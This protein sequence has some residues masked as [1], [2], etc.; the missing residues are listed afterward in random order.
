ME[1]QSALVW[2]AISGVSAVVSAIGSIAIAWMVYRFT[3]Q[4]GKMQ[5]MKDINS[6]WQIWNMAI[7]SNPEVA[8]FINRRK[9]ITDGGCMS[10]DEERMFA[11]VFYQVN[12]L[13]DLMLAQEAGLVDDEFT[14]ALREDAQNYVFSEKEMVDRIMDGRWGYP[15]RFL[16]QMKEALRAREVADAA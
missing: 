5:A 9:K 4:T 12:I 1:D 11:S 2:S 3:K 15:D 6:Q 7:I 16:L 14:S 10:A 8:E 13:Y